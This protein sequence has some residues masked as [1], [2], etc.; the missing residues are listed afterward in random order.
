MSTTVILASIP[1]R[2]HAEIT[3]KK[4]DSSKDSL[5]EALPSPNSPS[6]EAKQTEVPVREEDTTKG[7]VPDA[8]KPEATSKDPSKGIEAF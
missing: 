4:T 3:A 1:P 5:V 2:S 7:V 6:R 8:T